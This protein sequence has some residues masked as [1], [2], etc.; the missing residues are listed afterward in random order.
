MG[1]MRRRSGYR[2]ACLVAL[3]AGLHAL[4]AAANASEIEPNGLSV[5]QLPSDVEVSAAAS[6]VP[7]S[8]VHLD[9]LIISRGEMLE[10]RLDAHLAPVGF[11]PL[12]D[13]TAQMVL[14]GGT[15]AVDLGWYNVLPGQTMPPA[16][17]QIFSLV[18]APDPLTMPLQDYTPG[19]GV[20]NPVAT[21]AKLRKDARYA[22]GLIGFAMMGNDKSSTPVCTQTHFT[23]TALNPLCTTAECLNKPWIA[24]LMYQSTSMED[25]YYFLFEEKPVTPT[26]FGND[27]DFNDQVFL[28]TGV[29]CD[30]GGLPCDTGMLGV[31]KRGTTRCGKMGVVSCVQDVPVSPDV[32]DGLDND[33][34][35]IV[36]PD[37]AA[38][39]NPVQICD[40]GRCVDE[41][42]DVHNPCAA[43]LVCNLGVCKQPSCAGVVCPAGKLCVS[44]ACQDGCVAN[45]IPVSCP[46]GQTCRAGRCV[47]P[48]AG[49]ACEG[50]QVC[51]DGACL[52]PCSCRPCPAG[53]AC[54]P[55]DRCVDLGCDR[56]TCPDG[57]RCIAGMCRGPCY[58][59][60][61]PERDF[62]SADQCIPAPAPNSAG[63]ASGMSGA[64]TGGVG[65]RTGKDASADAS[66]A[67][68]DGPSAASAYSTC[69]CD[70]GGP[71]AGTLALVWGILTLA[72][73]V[74]R[75]RRA[76]L[77]A[78]ARFHLD[79]TER[80]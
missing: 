44:G 46:H 42:D 30:G 28:V 69:S 12:C 35:G 67:E 37:A 61:C 33:C 47:D 57:M 7:P 14:R 20:Q 41:C 27:G 1:S 29:T 18:P 59:T 16:A 19:V 63:G 64:G 73:L 66:A 45:G 75:R 70:V 68:G 9:Q 31:C 13:L 17:D 3:I 62:C 71:P 6:A 55:E 74:A 26:D 21:I 65:G 15:C 5:P 51:E 40:R 60:L 49:I 72:S 10:S 36:D 56:T 54:G 2:G 76:E 78:R 25:A 34:D 22:G 80:Q 39:A 52:P 77:A 48:C 79:A 23:D 11:A 4:C 8:E 58:L 50:G 24:S 32:C 53:K 38:C 43:G